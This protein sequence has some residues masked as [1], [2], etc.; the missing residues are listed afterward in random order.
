MSY[1]SELQQQRQ[2]KKQTLSAKGH[3]LE[4]F[5]VNQSSPFGLIVPRK[6]N[7]TV[8]MCT[9]PWVQR[10]SSLVAEGLWEWAQIV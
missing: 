10:P 3:L 7:Q 4:L 8:H 2:L 9:L 6:C 1:S 5:T